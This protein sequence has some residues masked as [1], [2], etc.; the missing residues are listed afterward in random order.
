MAHNIQKRRP[1]NS[2]FGDLGGLFDDWFLPAK[3]T[4]RALSPAMDIEEDD[5][6]IT[7]LLELPGLAKD[8]V[9][10]TLE[11]GVLTVAGEKED[12]R[13]VEAKRY[14]VFERRYGSFSRAIKLP[15]GVDLT[16]A[17]ATFNNG[18]LRVAVPKAEAAKPRTLDIG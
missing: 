8:D 3:N 6:H 5:N 4:E 14:H 16:K 17:E 7:V 1:V 11:D 10:I 15:T 13:D 12:D 9:T 18:V 2:P